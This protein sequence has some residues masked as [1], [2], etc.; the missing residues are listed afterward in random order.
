MCILLFFC[1]ICRLL[2]ETTVLSDLFLYTPKHVLFFA[3]KEQEKDYSAKERNI[4]L[5]QII[6]FCDNYTLY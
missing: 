1:T 5:R 4:E 2:G 6:N 3:L